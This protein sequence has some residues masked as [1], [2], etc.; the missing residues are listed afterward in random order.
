M[1]V[2]ILAAVLA[3]TLAVALPPAT[4][5][6]LAADPAQRVG[7][8]ALG[9]ANFKLRVSPGAPLLTWDTGTGQTA[10]QIPSIGGFFR[11]IDI[12]PGPL[13]NTLPG[14]ATSFTDLRTFNRL[15]YCYTVAPLGGVPQAALGNSDVLCQFPQS[16]INRAQ[17]GNLTLGLNQTTT[18]NLVWTPPSGTTP[19]SYVV[20]AQNVF[21]GALSTTVLPGTTTTFNHSTAG[22]QQCYLVVALGGSQSP[23]APDVTCAFPNLFRFAVVPDTQ[24]GAAGRSITQVL[25]DIAQGMTKN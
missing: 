7:A 5:E 3:L 19:A 2:S 4:D 18:T 12:L 8:S 6:V 24:A 11:E 10:Y 13:G 17:A 1:R 22:S 21:T 15:N 23:S 20:L 16:G 14:N 9:G 25:Q